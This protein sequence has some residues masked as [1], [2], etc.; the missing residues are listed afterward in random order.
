MQ[1]T[2]NTLFNVTSK[3]ATVTDTYDYNEIPYTFISAY[4]N[5]TA[6]L[7]NTIFHQ[8]TG[9]DANSDIVIGT[10]DSVTFDL[11]VSNDKVKS[12]SYTII[13]DVQVS[14]ASAVTAPGSAT[15]N[16][17]TTNPDEPLLLA[18][19]DAAL[20]AGKTPVIKFLNSS[21][22]V[23]GT[24][25][26]TETDGVN[27]IYFDSVTLS[28]YATIDSV[29]IVIDYSVTKEYTFDNC[30]VVT[31][32]LT[33]NINC[34]AAQITLQDTTVYPSYVSTLTREMT[35]RY[36]R[37]ADG[38]E[39]EAAV[40]TS[41]PSL[42]VGPYI[43]SGGYLFSLESTMSWTQADLLSVQ[44]VATM[45]LNKDVQCDAALCKV[46][47]CLYSLW[48]KYVAAV[49]IGGVN[50]NDLFHQNFIAM[51]YVMNYQLQL[52]CGNTDAAA[53]ILTNLT[54]FLAQDGSTECNCGC[55]DSTNPTVPTKIYPLYSSIALINGV[56]N[57]RNYQ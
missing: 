11:P 28:S 20:L 39:V 5:V 36:P 31:P 35:L 45:D 56:E 51:G 30:K 46:S 29:V 4:G 9:Y 18:E 23:L 17:I 49:K 44:Q 26:I 53:L 32:S 25:D 12:G 22:V 38:S 42:T 40:T 54:T 2:I 33:A 1:P 43:W 13:Y 48:S 21:S 37:L 27:A 55:G 47:A 57:A 34:A 24:S 3:Q 7:G 14:S 6:K 50:T 41:N 15:F 10:N 16:N 8:T 19:I 52:G